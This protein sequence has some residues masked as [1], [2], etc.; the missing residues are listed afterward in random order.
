LNLSLS[1]YW[2]ASSDF[3][4]ANVLVQLRTST[5]NVVSQEYSQWGS[6]GRASNGNPITTSLSFTEV[7]TLPVG[8]HA[9][10]LWGRIQNGDSSTPKFNM[11]AGNAVSVSAVLIN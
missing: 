3:T 11:D 5:G 4:N 8:T 1:G 7:V 9:L 10:E 6:T 2:T